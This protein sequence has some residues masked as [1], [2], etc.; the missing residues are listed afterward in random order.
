MVSYLC[1]AGF[2]NW[3]SFMISLVTVIK[4]W[5]ETQLCLFLTKFVRSLR[6]SAVSG[7]IGAKFYLL[8]YNFFWYLQLSIQQIVKCIRCKRDGVSVYADNLKMYKVLD[9]TIRLTCKWTVHYYATPKRHNHFQTFT[10]NVPPG[11]MTCPTQS[12]QLSPYPSSRNS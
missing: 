3:V 12:Q 8:M 11:G 10:W 4:T 1:Y 6:S 7:L 5:T 9:N 2:C